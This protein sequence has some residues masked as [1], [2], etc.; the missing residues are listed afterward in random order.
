MPAIPAT[1]P[2]S[3]S[4]RRGPPATTSVK[5]ADMRPRISSGV[6]VWRIVERQTAL[7][8]SAAPATS[9]HAAPTQSWS[10]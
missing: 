3:T 1:V 6:A 10:T 4:P 9:R 7:T 8:L 5:I 2:D